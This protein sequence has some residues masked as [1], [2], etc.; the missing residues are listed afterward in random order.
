MSLSLPEPL[1]CWVGQEVFSQSSPI[2]AS[3]L[4]CPWSCLGMVSVVMSTKR[5]CFVLVPDEVS[6]F[7]P[8]ASSTEAQVRSISLRPGKAN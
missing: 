3:L 2:P 4:A 1:T 6:V 7:L 5:P 8:I